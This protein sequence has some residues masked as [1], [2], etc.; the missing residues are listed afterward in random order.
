[1]LDQ[2]GELIRFQT[3]VSTVKEA[4][5]AVGVSH[6]C[7]VKTIVIICGGNPLAIITRGDKRLDLKYLGE[8]LKCGVLR[9]AE[10]DEVKRHTGYNVGGVP[11][12]LP[13]KTY[14]D[15]DVLAREY[16]YG[17][18]GDEYTLLKFSPR[19]LAKRL[20]WEILEI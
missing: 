16:V 11:P 3:R 5:R 13:I 19:E 1:M 20:S 6:S 7:I 18:G 15:S 2:Y 9:L 14:I 8:K 10:P 4:A 12:I 17:G